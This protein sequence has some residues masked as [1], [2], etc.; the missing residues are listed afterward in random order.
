MTN[1]YIRKIVKSR[2]K[3]RILKSKWIFFCFLF[4]LWWLLVRFSN[5]MFNMIGSWDSQSEDKILKILKWY[6][7]KIQ[8]RSYT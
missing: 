1:D 3:N 6:G 8:Q 7:G 4:L 5:I 2:I